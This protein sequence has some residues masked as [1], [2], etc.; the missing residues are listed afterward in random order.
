MFDTGY[1]LFC[2]NFEFNNGDE[3][4]DKYFIVLKRTENKVIVGSLPT[5]NNKIPAF[6]NVSHGCVNIEERC[7][8]CYIFEKNRKICENGFCFDLETFIYGDDLDTYELDIVEANY[9]LGVSYKVEGV[10]TQDEYKNILDCFLNSR[11]VKNKIKKQ[12]R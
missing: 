8:N 10:L 12:L 6:A 1:L 4:K 9:K 7:Y 11:S 5:R 2:K 3:P